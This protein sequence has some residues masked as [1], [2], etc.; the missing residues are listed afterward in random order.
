MFYILL[1]LTETKYKCYFRAQT[2]GFCFSVSE[3]MSA[4]SQH[5]N[6]FIGAPLSLDE[7]FRWCRCNRKGL[8][9]VINRNL[10]LR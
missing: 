7:S 1:I 9:L 2:C 8:E 5:F 3:T 10:F 4:Y 6:D